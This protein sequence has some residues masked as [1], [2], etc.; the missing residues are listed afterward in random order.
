[1][2]GWR[3]REERE[4]IVVDTVTFDLLASDDDIVAEYSSAI[5]PATRVM[6]LTHMIHWTGRVLP[7]ARL[8]ALARQHGIVTIVDAAQ[9]FAQSPVS[10]RLLGCDFFVTSLHKWLGAP[11]GNGMLVGDLVIPMQDSG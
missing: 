11:V 1:M 5:R 4:R 7:V 8:I 2:G 3:Q 6:H 10:V 9:S